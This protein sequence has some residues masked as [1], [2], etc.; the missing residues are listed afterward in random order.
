[1]GPPTNPVRFTDNRQRLHHLAAIFVSPLF[2][3]ALMRKLAICGD[4]RQIAGAAELPA[5]SRSRF[6]L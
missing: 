4:A 6:V 1:M 3:A 5:N 2:V